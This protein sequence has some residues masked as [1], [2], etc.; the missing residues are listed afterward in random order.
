MKISFAITVCNEWVELQKLL[1]YL[2]KN[3]KKEDEIVILYD[4]RN[5]HSNVEDFLRAQSI[6]S[7][8]GFR[9]YAEEFDN[10]FA[11]WKNKLNSLCTGDYIFQIDADEI[12]SEYLIKSM[13][14]LLNQNGDVDLFLV[15]RI[16]TVEGITEGHIQKWGWHINDKGWINW[17]DY[18]CRLYKRL[19]HI[20]WSGEVH[21]RI[22]G[23]KNYSHLPME[24][25][26]CL[27]HPKDIARQERQNNYY[28]TI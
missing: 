28:N 20:A 14:E 10:H 22:R 26:W 5:G 23:T 3:K 13:H 2:L 1:P 12:P 24:E 11:R 6:Q 21:E 19:P 4:K 15:P 16:N 25:H 8:P 9:W 18:Q 27:H 7:N 17:P